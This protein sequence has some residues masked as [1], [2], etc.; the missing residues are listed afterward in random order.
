LDTTTMN[1]TRNGNSFGATLTIQL[2][3][4]RNRGRRIGA[5][6]KSAPSAKKIPPSGTE[7]LK[8]RPLRDETVGALTTIG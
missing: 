6:A 8:A 3:T 7:L 1:M 5:R 4:A 2:V